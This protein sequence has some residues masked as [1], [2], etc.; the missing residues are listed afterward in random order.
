MGLQSRAALLLQRELYKIEHSVSN[1]WGI[2]IDLYR[3]NL[4]Q[5]ICSIEGLQGSVFE[6][7]TFQVMIQF[8]QEYDE[9]QPDVCF[10][11]IPFHPNINLITGKPCIDYLDDSNQWEC[12]YS[13]VSLLLQLQ[14]LLEFPVLENSVNLAAQDLYMNSPKLY[15]Q[16]AR[17]SVIASRRIKGLLI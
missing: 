10:T 15:E 7:G 13:I 9:I 8:S 11:T 5:W 4:F 16:M 17:D 14:V 2:S 6:G 1:P 12:G 3:N